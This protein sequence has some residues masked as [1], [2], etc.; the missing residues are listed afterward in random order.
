MVVRKHALSLVADRKCKIYKKI[1]NTVAI[2][3]GVVRRN[4]KGDSTM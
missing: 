2:A 1:N 4:T 3:Y